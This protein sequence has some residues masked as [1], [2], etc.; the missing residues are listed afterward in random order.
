M[1]QA[2]NP[3]AHGRDKWRHHRRYNQQISPR[4]S[5]RFASVQVQ[6][7]SSP[8]AILPLP[9]PPLPGTPRPALACGGMIPLPMPAKITQDHWM[10]RWV[11]RQQRGQQQ[12]HG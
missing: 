6:K 12:R 5:A 1:Q 7:I 3:V 8:G 2:A 9:L 4:R 10:V 11:Q